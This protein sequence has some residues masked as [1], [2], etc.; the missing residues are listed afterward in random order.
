MNK[1]NICATCAF[2]LESVLKK[3]IINLGYDIT[4]SQNGLVGIKGDLSDAF[5]L[6]LY[7]RCANRVLIS[8]GEFKAFSFDELFDNTHNL[9][10]AEFLP[11][12][13]R[14]NAEKITSVNS[15]LFSKTDCQRIIKK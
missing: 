14:F 13:A 9:N 1:Y 12:D 2:G 10:W 11:K 7:L 6:N 3:E 4:L 8:V 15:K 5:K